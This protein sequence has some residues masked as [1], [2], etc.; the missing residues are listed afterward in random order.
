MKKSGVEIFGLAVVVVWGP[1]SEKLKLTWLE[2]GVF[3]D[4]LR[5]IRDGVDGRRDLAWS[6]AEHSEAG[7]RCG[8]SVQC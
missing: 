2:D 3:Q 4:E 5:E 8:C 7:R 6:G 1:K